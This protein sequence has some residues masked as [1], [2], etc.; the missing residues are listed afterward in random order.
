MPTQTNVPIS[1]QL[2]RILCLA[3][4]THVS[5]GWMLEQLGPRSFGLTFFVMGLV[6]LVPG[7]STFI[8]AL[9]AW[10]ALQLIRGRKVASLPRLVRERTIS[11]EK[12]A[13]LSQAASSRLAVIERLVRP[14]WP[15]AIQ[16]TRSLTGFVMLLLGLTMVLPIPF[17]HL[18][19]AFVILILALAYLE[20]DG[21][22]LTVGFVAA[23][24]SL[25]ITATAVWGTIETI[26]FL[27]PAQRP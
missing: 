25:A 26:D 22:A 1:V 8:G 3:E 16:T 7:L 19:P 10:P 23:L 12:L 18:M 14:R 20:E 13:R 11:I 24:A 6:G 5:I 27:D 21:I 15:P 17:G 4:G 2:S 9:V